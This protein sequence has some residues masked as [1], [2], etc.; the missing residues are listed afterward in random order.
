MLNSVDFRD[1]VKASKK[2]G[3][4]PQWKMALLAWIA[5]WPASMFVWLIVKPVLGRNF[6]HVLAAG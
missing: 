5:V 2:E 6:P 4:G 3:L 1:A